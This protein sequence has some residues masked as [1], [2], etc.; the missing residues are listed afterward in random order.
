M[1]YEVKTIIRKNGDKMKHKRRVFIAVHTE[2]YELF[3]LSWYGYSNSCH[4]VAKILLQ[5][6]G[7]N[8]T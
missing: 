4:I 8:E 2:T 3:R 1:K 5:N 6:R 7:E